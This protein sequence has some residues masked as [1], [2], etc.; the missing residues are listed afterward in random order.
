M[1]LLR[2]GYTKRTFTPRQL[3]KEIILGTSIGHEIL[4][5]VRQYYS[6][7]NG[8]TINDK[9]LISILVEQYGID[10]LSPILSRKQTAIKNVSI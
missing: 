1:K 3:I 2:I 4:S 10:N 7:R 9:D 5:I 8:K 6:L